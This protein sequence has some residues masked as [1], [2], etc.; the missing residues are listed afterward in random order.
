MFSVLK[1][2]SRNPVP[3]SLRPV[4]GGGEAYAGAVR[5]ALTLLSY[6]PRS[7]HEVRQRLTGRRPAEVVERVIQALRGYGYLDDAGFARTW[8]EARERRRPRGRRRLKQELRQFGVAEAVIEEAL[9]GFDAGASCY[10]AG[11]KKA[12]LLAGRNTTPEVFR[13]RLTDF[14]RRRGFEYDVV[15]DTVQR[16]LEESAAEALPGEKCADEEEG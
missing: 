11:A 16:L 1:G 7:E 13:R 2:G 8:R 5:A 14:L 6:R 10:R 12:R 3:A 15:R 9:E 4:E